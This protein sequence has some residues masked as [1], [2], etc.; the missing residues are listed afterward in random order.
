MATDRA[1]YPVFAPILDEFQSCKAPRY[2]NGIVIG[3]LMNVSTAPNYTIC[4]ALAR[5]KHRFE[6]AIVTLGTTEIPTAAAVTMFGYKLNANIL[7]DPIMAGISGGFGY[8]KRERMDGKIKYCVPWIYN[9]TFTPPS[10]S[11]ITKG[12]TVTFT[13]PSL[14]GTALSET[15]SWRELFYFDSFKEAKAFLK[16]K[17]GIR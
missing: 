8:I 7:T 14:T 16:C 17:A 11:A 6:Y 9:V 10:D 12:E 3:K 5:Y 13:T 4:S 1:A 2:G 15:P